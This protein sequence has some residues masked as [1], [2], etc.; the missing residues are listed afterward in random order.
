[1]PLFTP[2]QESNEG[3]CGNIEFA[4]FVYSSDVRLW[5]LFN[6]LRKVSNEI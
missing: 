6:I 5:T 2:S 3:D 4:W 1:M